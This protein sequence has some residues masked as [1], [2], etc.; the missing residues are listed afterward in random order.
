MSRDVSNGNTKNVFRDGGG[1]NVCLE[2]L[3]V[4]NV[5]L[6]MLVVCIYIVM[7]VSSCWDG[8]VF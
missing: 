1:G 2:M 8:N 5:C 3:V 6:E 4:G 7:C